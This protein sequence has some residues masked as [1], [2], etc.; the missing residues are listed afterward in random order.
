MTNNNMTSTYKCVCDTKPTKET[1]CI[2]DEFGYDKKT[3]SIK[4]KPWMA[5]RMVDGSLKYNINPGCRLRACTLHNVIGSTTESLTTEEIQ[6][7]ICYFNR[8]GVFES[9]IMFSIDFRVYS[10]K[11]TDIVADN[12]NIIKLPKCESKLFL[13]PNYIIQVKPIF[14]IQ[15]LTF[16]DRRCI[17]IIP[18][19]KKF[20]PFDS[21]GLLVFAITRKEITDDF[22]ESNDFICALSKTYEVNFNKNKLITN[23]KSLDKYTTNN[24]NKMQQSLYKLERRCSNSTTELNDE[25]LVKLFNTS[26]K[27]KKK[28]NKSIKNEYTDETSLTQEKVELEEIEVIQEESIE[29]QGEVKDT[30]K[31]L[32][33]EREIVSELEEQFST[34]DFVEVQNKVVKYK[35]NLKHKIVFFIDYSY[36]IEEMLINV[37]LTN[38]KIMDFF[39]SVKYINVMKGIHQDLSGNIASTHFNIIVDSVEYHCYVKFNKIR[40]MTKIVDMMM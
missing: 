12:D 40:S 39:D 19:K 16:K 30:K 18:N 2:N 17:S 32:E 26:Q 25:E 11:L 14:I 20:I 15:G 4:L 9:D 33:Y 28:K 3:D 31:T 29:K 13:F 35:P 6:H 8:G 1:L 23:G 36:A 38:T 10:N 7:T 37:Y 22:I 34:N 24:L 5:F 27:K 21:K